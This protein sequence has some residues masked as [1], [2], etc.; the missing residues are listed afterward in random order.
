M[1]RFLSTGVSVSILQFTLINS[2]INI[3]F[4]LQRQVIP[5]PFEKWFQVEPLKEYHMKII[6]MEDFMENLAST[7][8]SGERIG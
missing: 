5:V 2:I 6:T 3:K 8:W 7:V 4:L 1:N